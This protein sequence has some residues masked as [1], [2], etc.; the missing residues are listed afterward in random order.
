[1]INS[2]R[3]SGNSLEDNWG[4]PNK[5][6]EKKMGPKIIVGL[7]TYM[8]M[9]VEWIYLIIPLQLYNVQY[10]ILNVTW[11]VRTYSWDR[12][13]DIPDKNT[14]SVIVSEDEVNVFCLLG[15]T[16]LMGVLKRWIRNCLS[17]SSF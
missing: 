13:H 11:Y 14:V 5:G 10:I 8:E 15:R 16:V 2:L 7:N 4:I 17:V 1:M 3:T 12:L 6:P 9:N